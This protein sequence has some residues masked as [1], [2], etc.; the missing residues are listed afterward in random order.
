MFSH[1]VFAVRYYTDSVRLAIVSAFSGGVFYTPPFSE[2]LN[3]IKARQ[4]ASR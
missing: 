4:R 1:L 2:S 3:E